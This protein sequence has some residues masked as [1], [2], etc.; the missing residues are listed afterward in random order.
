M[1]RLRLAVVAAILG[2][3][4]CGGDDEAASPAGSSTAAAGLSERCVAADSSLMAPLGGGM[5]DDQFRLKNGQAV[6][7]ADHDDIYFVSAEIYGPDIEDVTIATW[8]TPSLG[9]AEAIYSID[10]I[11]KEY[12]DLRDGTEVAELAADDDGVEESRACV[13]AAR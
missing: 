10:D 2:V 12:S 11:S 1:A 9:G 4:G 8:A 6:K 7:S 13:E 3:A 5:K